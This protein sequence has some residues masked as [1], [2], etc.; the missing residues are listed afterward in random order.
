M[1]GRIQRPYGE[2]YTGP[3]LWWVEGGGGHISQMVGFLC[4]EFKTG[5]FLLILFTNKRCIVCI[6]FIYL[7]CIA[8][9]AT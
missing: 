1:S 2:K 8:K 7:M 9:N 5:F 4:S 3:A 6:H